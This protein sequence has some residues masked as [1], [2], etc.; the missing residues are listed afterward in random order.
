MTQRIDVVWDD[1]ARSRI[2][3]A[4]WTR[5]FGEVPEDD[6]EATVDA[7]LEV[8]EQQMVDG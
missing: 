6:L 8:I 5:L 3:A 4:L 7:A 2:R 1:N